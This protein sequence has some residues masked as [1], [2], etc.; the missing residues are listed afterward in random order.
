MRKI[1]SI[2]HLAVTLFL[3]VVAGFPAVFAAS[4]E[5]RPLSPG[6]SGNPSSFSAKPAGEA[7]RLRDTLKNETE[8]VQ[9]RNALKLAPKTFVCD[10]FTAD[11]RSYA[12]CTKLRFNDSMR[13]VLALDFVQQDP[14]LH[15]QLRRLY[16]LVRPFTVTGDLKVTYRQ[17]PAGIAVEYEITNLY[18]WGRRASDRLIREILRI[19]GA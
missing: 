6:E 14:Y 1:K 17:V 8:R 5:G 9:F 11:G 13:K 18:I 16:R 12:S 19:T 2:K 15:K 7:I 10:K 3:L 4:P